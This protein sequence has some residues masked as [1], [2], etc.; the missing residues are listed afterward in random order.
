M[1]RALVRFIGEISAHGVPEIDGD[2]LIREF[3]RI[4]NLKMRTLEE[5]VLFRKRRA[6][7]LKGWKTRRRS[8]LISPA[9]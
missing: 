2:A 3:G 8:R 6:S 7:A 5:I 9:R 1:S 4:N